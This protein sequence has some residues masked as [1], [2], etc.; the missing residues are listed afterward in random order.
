[1]TTDGKSNPDSAGHENSAAIATAAN[2]SL[3]APEVEWDIH[4]ALQ[5]LVNRACYVTGAADAIIAIGEG[6]TLVCKAAAGR[7]AP[8]A[9]TQIQIDGG[10]T[11]E[12]MA[13][14]VTKRQPVRCDDAENDSRVSREESARL[15]VSSVLVAP[16]VHGS[17]VIGIFQLT[18]GRKSAFE[19]RDVG[20]LLRLVTAAQTALEE[21]LVKEQN[22]NEDKAIDARDQLASL[23]EPAAGSGKFASIALRSGRIPLPQA[24]IAQALNDNS[25]RLSR[26]QELRRCQGCGFPISTDRTLCIDCEAAEIAHGKFVEAAPALYPFTSETKRR[27]W[28]DEHFYTIGVVLVTLLT[29]IVLFLWAR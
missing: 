4:A 10:L 1:M 23:P 18:A 19:E 20:C 13:E 21:A 11:S 8:K 27:N 5:L 12:L 15:G 26:G 29:I 25:K 28:L 16:L 14:C 6:D 7:T 17:E 24:R 2:A 3:P 22:Q 9:G